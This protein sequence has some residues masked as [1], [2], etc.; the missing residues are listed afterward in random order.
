MGEEPN[1]RP[2]DEPSGDPPEGA[3]PRDHGWSEAGETPGSPSAGSEGSA[4][5]SQPPAGPGSNEPERSGTPGTR[6][7]A[8]NLAERYVAVRATTIARD[9][10]PGPVV[11][12]AARGPAVTTMVIAVALGTL[13]A[14]TFGIPPVSPLFLVALLCAPI[15]PWLRLEARAIERWRSDR[16]PGDA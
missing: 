10:G 16:A 3:S 9:G 4:G 13:F 8:V 6:Q 12:V 15:Y 1:H 2:E 11:R 14:V 7:V 5:A